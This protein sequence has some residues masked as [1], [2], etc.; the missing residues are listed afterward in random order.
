M[1]AVEEV[2]P[3]VFA[4]SISQLRKHLTNTIAVK[5]HSPECV[6]LLYQL[7][8]RFQAVNEMVYMFNL[9]HHEGDDFAQK[10][11]ALLRDWDAETARRNL[12]YR[13]V[14][15]LLQQRTQIAKRVFGSFP[16]TG[17]ALQGRK[18][19]TYN[20]TRCDETAVNPYSKNVYFLHVIEVC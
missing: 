2:D 17:G 4:A 12:K 6:N 19:S 15:Y 16:F 11:T 9:Q 5:M 1:Q 18:R 13:D 8:A 20:E 3:V 14:E 7:Q 10:I